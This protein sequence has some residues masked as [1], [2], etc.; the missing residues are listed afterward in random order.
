[1][2]R[3]FRRFSVAVFV[4]ILAFGVENDLFFQRIASLEARAL[5]DFSPRLDISLADT[6]LT[7]LEEQKGIKFPANTLTFSLADKVYTYENVEL[8]ARGN[9]SWLTEKKSYQLKFPTKT[10]LFGLGRSRTWILVANAYD[11]THLRNDFAQFLAEIVGFSRSFRGEYVELFVDGNYRGL[12]YLM[13]KIN[14]TTTNL[15]DST[16][17]IVEISNIHL[18]LTDLYVRADNS[19]ALS[20]ADTPEK[21]PSAQ[22]ALLE[23]FTD[24]YNSLLSAISAQDYSAIESLIDVDSF[25]RYCLLSEFSENVDAYKTSFYLYKRDATDKIHADIAWDFDL[26][27]GNSN[28][29]DGFLDLGPS[30]SLISRRANYDSDSRIIYD[31]LD[32]PEFSDRVSEIYLETIVPREEEILSYLDHK[33]DAIRASAIANNLTWGSGNFDIEAQK[34]QNWVLN[35]IEYFSTVHK[36]GGA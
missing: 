19:D 21:D 34:L 11:P 29:L 30:D 2:L 16:S 6:T 31:L 7:T 9:S 24:S 32:F 13:P 8:N 33:K 20:L 36:N 22:L 14:S 12:Y 5:G 35:R 4:F 23:S 25:A 15:K 10:E 27:F 17:L 3:F 28:S 1:M 26:A 18:D